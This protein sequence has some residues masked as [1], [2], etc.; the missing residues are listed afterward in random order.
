M[1]K[2]QVGEIIL[3]GSWLIK[4]NSMIADSVCQRIEWNIKNH[5][6]LITDSPEN[7]AWESLYKNPDDGLYWEKTYPQGEM[8]AGGPPELRCISKEVVNRK[9]KLVV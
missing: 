4:N 2:I 8:H 3:T 7:G 5:L 1:M 9:Y 6:E